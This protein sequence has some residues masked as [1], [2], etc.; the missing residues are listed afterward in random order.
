M[1]VSK[2]LIESRIIQ[3]LNFDKMV[4]EDTNQGESVLTKSILIIISPQQL[5]IACLTKAVT[6]V[7]HD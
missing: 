6:L 5:I 1:K 4:R 3:L 2:N 7:R